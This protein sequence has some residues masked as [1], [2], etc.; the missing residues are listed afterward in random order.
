MTRRVEETRAQ[1]LRGIDAP[2][3]T[4]NEAAAEYIADLE[5]RGKDST[6]SLQDA[7]ILAEEVGDLPLS[8]VHQRALQPWIDRQHGKRSSGTVAR[9]LSTCTTVLTYAARVLRD[10]NKPWLA[11]AVP[12]LVAPDWGRRQPYRLTWEEQDRLIAEL[13]EHL[14]RP[15]LFALATGARQEEICSLRWEQ[16]RAVRGLPDLSVWWIPPAVRKANA[17]KGAS[18]QEGRHLIANAMAR[19]VLTTGASSEEW[20]FPAPHGGRLLRLNNHGWRSAIQRADLPVRVHDLRHTFGERLATA[21]VPFDARKT[22]LG[23]DHADITAHYS[24]PGLSRLLEEAEK[25]RRDVPILR[26][27]CTN[28]AQ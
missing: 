27:L 14:I 21:G 9:A 18:A 5:R 13:P 10:G 3:R 22:L 7:K 8:H 15:T 1:L 25:V 23:H 12:K 24:T 4:W 26:A 2:E 28:Y 19:S 16:A 20:V 6:R 11:Q 17:R